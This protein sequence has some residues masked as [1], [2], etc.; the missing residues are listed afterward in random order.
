[1]VALSATKRRGKKL[2]NNCSTPHRR[3]EAKDLFIYL[4]AHSAS[5]NNSLGG[6]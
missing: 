6:L 3:L 5:N 2:K 4:E 1:M